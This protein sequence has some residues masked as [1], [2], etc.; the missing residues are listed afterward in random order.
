[1]KKEV[2]YKQRNC[3]DQAKIEK[4]LT[5]ERTG[6]L[7][8]TELNE[9]YAVPLNFIFY[10]GCIYFH[11]MGSGRKENI[12]KSIAPVCFTVYKEYG[13]VT[14]P[15]PCHSDTSYISV[16]FFGKAEKVTDITEATAVLQALLEK[17]MPGY[18]KRAL[19]PDFVKKYR[20]SIDG[21][22]VS[23]YKIKPE[24]VTAKENA[25]DPDSI[26]SK[27]RSLPD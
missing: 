23:V 10:D 17:Y 2:F 24:V 20:S 21:N 16:I 14:D 6:V 25:A 19:L 26:F 8:M 27:E 13:T 11:G 5:S 7:G 22:A 4:L 3:T 15:V 9:P 18:Y 12:L 1:M